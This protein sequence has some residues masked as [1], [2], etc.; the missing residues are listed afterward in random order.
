M[1]SSLF[2]PVS[3]CLLLCTSQAGMPCRAADLPGRND[4][5][6]N[7][8]LIY[9]DDMGYGDLSCY[10]H[11]TIR[12]PHIDRLAAEGVKMNSFYAPAAVSSPSRA[13]LLTARYPVRSGMYGDRESVL[14][15]DTPRGLP[16]EEV[17]LADVMREAGY[18]TALIGKWH[19]GHAHPYLPDD[20]GFDYFYGLYSP[21]N[22]R[23]LPFMENET[24]LQ[25]HAD[26]PN[27][28]QMYTE[29]AREYIREHRDE[30]FFLFLSHAYPHLPVMASKQ[31][32]HTSRAGRYGDAVEELDWS[33][34]EVMKCLR[35]NGLDENTLVI[36]TSDNGPAIKFTPNNGGSAGHLRGGKGSG[37]EG[38]FRVPGI[39]R[40]PA[41]IPA[42]SVCMEIGTQL[43]LLPTI[44]SLC[45]AK[46]PED[47]PI[48]GVDLMPMLTGKQQS[49]RSEFA[50]YRGSRLAALRKGRHKAIFEVPGDW[51]TQT[52]YLQ[53]TARVEL[54]IFDLDLD[55]GEKRNIAPKRSELVEKFMQLRRKYMR[56]VNV[57]P[58]IND[59]RPFGSHNT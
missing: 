48:D 33:V 8:V 56:E 21:N 1:N 18:A 23:T 3:S 6:P 49:V 37:W 27:L 45:G 38:G 9:V 10:G 50:Y 7:V 39:F 44:A 53:D 40:F 12:T 17:T 35:E 36:F 15:P 13:G 58:S 25:E 59:E 19:Q 5:R 29:R 26:R 52:P 24:V 32:E 31:F 2:T 30:P 54:L 16:E 22:Y 11:P 34:G 14:F 51:Y 20:N 47:R 46:V 28:T 43:D 55:P 4:P 57:A 41:D 42:G